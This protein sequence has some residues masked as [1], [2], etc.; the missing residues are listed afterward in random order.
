MSDGHSGKGATFRALH[1]RAGGFLLPNPWDVGSA[2]LLAGLGYEAL[3]TTSAGMAFSLG[4]TDGR[5]GWEDVLQHCRG[6]VAA[7][8]LPVSADLERGLGD[9]PEDAASSVRLAAEAGLAGCSL[10]DSSGNA[11]HPIYDFEHAVERIRAAAEARN[12]L[13]HDFVLTARTENY[14][15]GRP[16]LDDTIRRL[17]AFEVAGADVLYA[18][19]L[20]DLDA[21]RAVCAAVT[22][23]VNVMYGMGG[24][25]YTVADLVAAGAARISVGPAFAWAAYGAMIET[26]RRLAE[27]GQMAYP[28]PM[29]GYSE[30]GALLAAGAPGQSQ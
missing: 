11:D 18:P 28:S 10:E 27:A 16:D 23:P 25:P 12:A 7:T 2:R 5:V 26:A 17:Q 30:I 8:D 14:F 9:S 24:E 22:K 3:A 19:G 6:L 1:E 4:V 15:N 29:A 21:V 20:P 13:P